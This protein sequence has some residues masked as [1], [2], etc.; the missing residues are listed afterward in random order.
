MTWI[1]ATVMMLVLVVGLVLAGCGD[2]EGDTTGSDGD[3][4]PLRILATTS[5]VGQLAEEVGGDHVQVDVLIGRGVDPHTYD[6]SPSDARKAADADIVLMIGL[7][8][9]DY[10]RSDI[11]AANDEAPI[12][13]ITDGVDLLEAGEHGE[14]DEAE[15]HDEDQVEFEDDHDHGEFDPHVWQDPLRAKV[16]VANIA[17]ALAE[18]DPDNADDYQENAS[19]YQ[20]RLDEVHAEIEAL[21]AEIPEENRVMITNHEAFAYFADRYGLEIV[22]TVIPGV[23]TEAEPSAQDIAALNKLI[24]EKGV[25]A[26]FAEELVDPKIAEQ[27]AADTG[28]EVVATLYTEQLGPEDSDAATLDQML[29]FNARAIAEALK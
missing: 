14:D 19:A 4:D 12:V 28:I 3:D 15:E 10:L 16:M 22:G 21:I 9:D 13:A 20:E 25:R 26:I 18:I 8:F 24:E 11:E 6:P 17:D 29:L 5:I 1:R 7:E 2:D 27:L 23:S